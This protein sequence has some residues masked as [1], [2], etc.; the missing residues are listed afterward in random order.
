MRRLI[1]I[2][3][4]F[5]CSSGLQAQIDTKDLVRAR[6]YINA[7]LTYMMLTEFVKTKEAVPKQW[8]SVAGVL[9]GNT[10]ENVLRYEDLFNTLSSG[11][12][13]TLLK[14]SEP[15]SKLDIQKYDSA[16]PE[17][18]SQ[19]LVDDALLV[20]E[21]AYKQ[22]YPSKQ[23]IALLVDD[24]KRLLPLRVEKPVIED[25]QTVATEAP[26][27][28]KEA[29]F[30][31][32]EYFNV[33]TLAALLLALA[34]TGLSAIAFTTTHQQR[35]RRGYKT[36]DTFETAYP[37]VTER[38]FLQYQEDVDKKIAAIKGE[39]SAINKPVEANTPAT[40]AREQP[41]PVPPAVQ[42][43]GDRPD[44]FYMSSPSNNYFPLTAKSLSKEN[45]LYRFLVSGNKQEAE[46]EVINDGAPIAQAVYLA[47]HYFEPACN[48]ENAPA[49]VV[50]RIVTTKKGKASYDGQKWIITVKAEIRYE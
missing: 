31:S 2:A 42:E 18:A 50:N 33:W 30:F 23:D 14:L 29:G 20:F 40:P 34:A 35:G 16:S 39:L 46:F 4:L 1:I 15:I 44:I 28:I 38:T 6:D 8:D 27:V 41:L 21:Q 10:V 13:L 11:F 45:T 5:L 25:T 49:G 19:T 24:V 36:R 48:A 12:S 43:P 47:S 26:A 7:R 3:T 32:L 22:Y 17:L 37:P 9:K